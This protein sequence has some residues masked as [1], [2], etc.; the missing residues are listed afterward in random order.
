[1][2]FDQMGRSNDYCPTIYGVSYSNRNSEVD[3][4]N[5]NCSMWQKTLKIAISPLIEGQ[6]NDVRIDFKNSLSCYLSPTK[7]KMFSDILK[8][9]RE[10]P[11]KF[12]NYGVPAGQTLITINHP[13]KENKNCGPIINIK[14]IG[15][16][17]NIEQSYSY[18]LKQD[19]NAVV[20]FNEKTGEFKQDFES[21]KNV[22]LDMLIIQI[23]EYV[24]ALTNAQSFANLVTMYPYM[25]KIAGK[26]GLDLSAR[27]R[28]GGYSTTSY[29]SASNSSG[30]VNAGNSAIPHNSLDSMMNG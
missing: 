15:Q 8:K 21:Y 14:K 12:S 25:D 22:E 26:L 30:M 18:E 24:K 17:H 5:L 2:A 13:S 29:F 9:F 1:M 20:G 10:D 7:A 6:D 27:Q 4:T 19:Y 16:D 11:V 28:T 23:D 3:K